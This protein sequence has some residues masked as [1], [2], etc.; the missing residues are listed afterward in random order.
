MGFYIRKS[1]SFGPLRLN[2]SKSGLG[3]SVGVKGARIGTGP[4][5]NYIHMGRHGL[6]YRQ[7]FNSPPTSQN[8]ANQPTPVSPIS[9]PDS[10]VSGTVISTADVTA[11]KDSSAEEL[12]NYIRGQHEK[13]ALAPWVAAS[14]SRLRPMRTHQTRFSPQR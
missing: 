10:I 13:A 8:T 9:P 5:G 3:Y 2:L 7:Y 6:Y 1:F 11:L 4:R 14:R 12:L